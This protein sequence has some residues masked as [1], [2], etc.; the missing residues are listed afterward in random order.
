[1]VDCVVSCWYL[2]PFKM[3][4]FWS[5]KGVQYREGW[6]CQS[7][8]H[9]IKWLLTRIDCSGCRLGLYLAKL[10]LYFPLI[11]M[12]AING[13]RYSPRHGNQLCFGYIVSWENYDGYWPENS[14]CTL[15]FGTK[16]V[17]VENWIVLHGLKGNF[18]TGQNTPPTAMWCTRNPNYH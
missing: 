1:M 17:V 18:G 3:F 16:R 13:I 12:F 9:Q 7:A 5:R 11:D 8:L 4:G 14:T 6:G 15:S 10:D 2:V